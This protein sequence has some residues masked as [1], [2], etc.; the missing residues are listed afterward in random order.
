MSYFKPAHTFLILSLLF[1]PAFAAGPADEAPEVTAGAP[2]TQTATPPGPPAA[3]PNGDELTPPAPGAPEDPAPQID[4][5]P[6]APAPP[7][8]PKP[9]KIEAPKNVR[10][11]SCV[12]RYNEEHPDSKMTCV[13]SID[14][15][16]YQL[17][18]K[19]DPKYSKLGITTMKYFNIPLEQVMDAVN[20]GKELKLDVKY[21]RG[22]SM[23]ECTIAFGRAGGGFVDSIKKGFCRGNTPNAGYSPYRPSASEG[24]IKAGT[25]GG[26]KSFVTNFKGSKVPVAICLRDSKEK[27]YGGIKPGPTIVAMVDLPTKF[28]N[29]EYI[30]PCAEIITGPLDKKNRVGKPEG[31]IMQ[32]VRFPMHPKATLRRQEAL[33]L[34]PIL[35]RVDSVV[36]AAPPAAADEPVAQ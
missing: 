8:A 23:D 15:L 27:T 26:Q 16:K 28:P 3:A 25:Y 12:K 9:A 33:R 21:D 30:G 4:A 5:A 34:F 10:K 1:P 31:T 36:R 35:P 18:G 11:S 6:V 17:L 14:E 19:K 32:A 13:S 22:L 7:V 29:R 20:T 24:G 2:P